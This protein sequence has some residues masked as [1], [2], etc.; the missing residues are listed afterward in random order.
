MLCYI[1]SKREGIE[2]NNTQRLAVACKGHTQ[3]GP[4]TS[5]KGQSMRLAS[6]KQAGCMA[7]WS[8]VRERHGSYV[9]GKTVWLCLGRFISVFQRIA[10]PFPLENAHGQEAAF[11]LIRGLPSAFILAPNGRGGRAPL[12]K[13]DGLPIVH[14]TNVRRQTFK[15]FA[16]R[17]STRIQPLVT[18]Q[19]CRAIGE[20]NYMLYVCL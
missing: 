3:V 14:S 17:L 8:M 20:I 11:A 2:R 12:D 6:W 18:Q 19:C 4:M 9:W 16:S 15:P 5:V 10:C 13:R 1:T 7:S